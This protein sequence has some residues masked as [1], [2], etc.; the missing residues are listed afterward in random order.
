MFV[1]NICSGKNTGRLPNLRYRYK[2][3][4][5]EID[6]VT[7]FETMIFSPKREENIQHTVTRIVIACKKSAEKPWVFFSTPRYPVRPLTGFLKYLSDFDLQFLKTKRPR[8]RH[9]MRKYLSRI[10]YSLRD[11]PACISYCQAFKKASDQISDIYDAIDSVLSYVNYDMDLVLKRRQATGHSTIFYFPVVVLDGGLFEAQVEG[12]QIEVHARHHIQLR[13][14]DE[15]D[16]F[17][18]DIVTKEHFMNFFELVEKDHNTFVEAINNVR[19]PKAHR[20]LIRAALRKQRRS[21][22]TDRE[23]RELVE[24]IQDSK[25]KAVISMM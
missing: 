24:L 8:L 20:S 1:L 15:N 5:R 2:G 3:Q 6:L 16:T 21:I 7:S 25:N 12:D 10:H 23:F 4:L 11:I 13:T 9:Q 17:V 19:F 22:R 18:V 14:D